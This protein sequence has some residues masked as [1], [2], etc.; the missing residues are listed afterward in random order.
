[1]EPGKFANLVVSNKPYFDEKSTVRYVFVEGVPYKYD[2]VRVSKPETNDAVSLVGTWTVTAD[3]P[4]G[5]KEEK[6]TIKQEGINYSGSVTTDEVA[7]AATLE[8]IVLN[9]KLLTYS[10]T[11]QAGGQS[12]K[13]DVQATVEGNSFTGTATRGGTGSFPLEAK[14]DPNP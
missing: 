7:E 13:V 1:V 5:K 11:I 8:A 6:I 2:P 3:S 14:K 10:Y 12:Y 9:G 4:Q